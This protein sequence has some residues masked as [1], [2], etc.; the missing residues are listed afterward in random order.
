MHPFLGETAMSLG[1]VLIPVHTT[2]S[3]SAVLSPHQLMCTEE[4]ELDVNDPSFINL[5]S[6]L[7]C[8]NTPG[9]IKRHLQTPGMYFMGSHVAQ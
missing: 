8:H 9:W 3:S 6:W 4:A 5:Q 2:T 7:Q 1:H